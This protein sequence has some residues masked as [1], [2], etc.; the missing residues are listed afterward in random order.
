[1]HAKGSDSHL[2][3]NLIDDHHVEVSAPVVVPSPLRLTSPR[4]DKSMNILKHQKDSY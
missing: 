1:M 2:V 4:R 3:M